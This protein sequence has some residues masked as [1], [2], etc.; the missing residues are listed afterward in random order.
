MTT[1]GNLLLIPPNLVPRAQLSGADL[2]G[3][4]SRLRATGPGA[5]RA[6]GYSGR[7]WGTRVGESLG[8]AARKKKQSVQS[9][10]VGK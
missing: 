2:H 3:A 9:L 7:I 1:W 6:L 4:S 10:E 5:M 8:M